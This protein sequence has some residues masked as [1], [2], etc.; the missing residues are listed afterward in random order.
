[1]RDHYRA[2]RRFVGRIF[3][4]N[5]SISSPNICR[6]GIE[7]L[8]NLKGQM[9]FLH[10]LSWDHT[11]STVLWRRFLDFNRTRSR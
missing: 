6:L 7:Q 4:R 9:H 2:C 3:V 5:L 1:V 8:Y 10:A 11:S